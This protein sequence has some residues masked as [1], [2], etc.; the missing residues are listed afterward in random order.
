MATDFPF[1]ILDVINACSISL[2]KQPKGDCVYFDCPVCGGKNKVQARIASGVYHCAK[3]SDFG[4]GMLDLYRYYFQCDSKTANK[5]MRE[6]IGQP[7][8]SQTKEINNR[9]EAQAKKVFAQNAN[10]ASEDT[11]NATYR[12]FLSLCTLKKSHRDNLIARGLSDKAISHFGFKS[13]PTE[14]YDHYRIINTLC[15]EGY[16]IQGVPGFFRNEGKRAE[17]NLFKRYEGILVPYI[18]LDNK[19]LG[20]QIRLEKPFEERKKDGTVKYIRYIW[21]S[22]VDLPNG[23]GRTTLP[24]ITSTRKVESTI[25]FTEGALKADIASFLGNRTFIAI[26]GVTQYS[27]LPELFK[28]LKK[29][30]VKRII[31]CYDADY[32]T[33]TNVQN[34]RNH[35]KTQIQKAGLQYL[36]LDWS[37]KIGK[38]IDDYLLALPKGKRKFVLYDY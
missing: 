6:Y 29:N 7:Y 26:A 22:S 14:P 20:F 16:N 9:Y 19:L 4:G 8:Y 10:L 12:R 11:I 31:D 34:A 28:K 18:S 36:R 13:V 15:R 1:N 32:R 25:F 21:F 3:C 24:H 27:I 23:C 17:F 38:G 37:E 35:L 30:G 5:K 2:S 33:N